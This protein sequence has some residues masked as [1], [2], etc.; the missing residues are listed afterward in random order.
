MSAQIQNFNRAFIITY[1]KFKKVKFWEK[2][3]M[4]PF[5]F[6][7]RKTVSKNIFVL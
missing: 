1:I 2:V 5:M 3:I 6:T 4:L 7:A